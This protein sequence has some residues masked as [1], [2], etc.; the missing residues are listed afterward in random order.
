MQFCSAPWL[1]IYQFYCNCNEYNLEYCNP[2]AKVCS[3]VRKI[4]IDLTI[5][6]WFLILQPLWGIRKDFIH[7]TISLFRKLWPKSCYTF[8]SYTSSF[9][10][11]QNVLDLSKFFCQTKYWFTYCAAVPTLLCQ[12]KRWFPRVDLFFVP[13]QNVLEQH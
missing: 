11:S 7:S 1:H 5:Q 9:Y 3:S 12:T 6:A 13:A 10:R 2:V 4:C 8:D